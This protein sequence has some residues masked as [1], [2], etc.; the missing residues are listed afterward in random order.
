QM[1][2]IYNALQVDVALP[3]AAGGNRTLTLEVE[4]HVGDGVVKTISMQP[5]DGLVRGA[6]VRNTGS[7]ITVPVGDGVK[8]HVFNALGQPLDV[9]ES[10]I[11]AYSRCAIPR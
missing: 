8:G 10:Q 6:A 9:Y 1:P 11:E 7:G 4:Q 5:T 3:E 2:E